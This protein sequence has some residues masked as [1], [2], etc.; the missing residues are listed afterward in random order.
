MILYSLSLIY[1][2]SSPFNI[3]VILTSATPC[4]RG[5]HI[6]HPSSTLL[7]QGHRSE[8]L[9]VSLLLE[10]EK[11]IGFKLWNLIRLCLIQIMNPIPL[12]PDT[13]WFLFQVSSICRFLF[14]YFHCCELIYI[15]HTLLNFL[16]KFSGTNWYWWTLVM[17]SLTSGNT[18]AIQSTLS[19]H[20][21]T[22]QTLLHQPSS[23][24]PERS[25]NLYAFVS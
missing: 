18:L 12:L 25:P 3:S 2:S 23:F 1:F 13:V 10:V 5:F 11:S 15:L 6:C 22:M 7:M 16:L 9:T 21:S 4:R 8:M 20:F 24:F 17:L 14:I 19:K